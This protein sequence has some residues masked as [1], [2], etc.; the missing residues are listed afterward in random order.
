MAASNVSRLSCSGNGGKTG[1]VD[2]TLTTTTRARPWRSAK[3]LRSA[4]S[5][6][7]ASAWVPVCVAG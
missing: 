7:A 4:E 2:D 6:L 5:A 3:A 1:S